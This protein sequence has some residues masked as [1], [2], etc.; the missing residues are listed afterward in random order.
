M[1][2]RERRTEVQRGGDCQGQ[3]GSVCVVYLG[4][5]VG[6]A[7][8]GPYEEAIVCDLRA[9]LHARG[10]QVL[11]HLVVGAGHGRQVEVAHT[12]QLQLE[13]QRRLQVPVNTVLLEL[14]TANRLKIHKQPFTRFQ[15][16]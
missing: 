15:L 9:L 11:V 12:V 16:I 2:N 4:D 6:V 14:R 7:D 3:R 1:T 10:P 13:G 8:D 5:E